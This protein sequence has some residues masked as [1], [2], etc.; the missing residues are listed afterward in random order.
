MQ[1]GQCIYLTERDGAAADDYETFLTWRE[2]RLWQEIQRVTGLG[3]MTDLE[4][5]AEDSA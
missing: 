5:T 1:L 3:E 4:T 2:K